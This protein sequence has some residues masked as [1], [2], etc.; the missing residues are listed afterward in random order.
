[1]SPTYLLVRE[2]AKMLKKV[3]CTLLAT[4]LPS[5]VLPVSGG[6]NSSMPLAGALM[7]YVMT[8]DCFIMLQALWHSVTWS[9]DGLANRASTMQ[10]Q[11]NIN[12]TTII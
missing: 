12:I 3:A 8:K 1:M 6:P 4:A 11:L 5:L 7:P 9:M 10:A 2:E